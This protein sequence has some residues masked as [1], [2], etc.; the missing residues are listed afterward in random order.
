MILPCK[1]QEVLALVL[2]DGK[3]LDALGGSIKCDLQVGICF[4]VLL[5]GGFPGEQLDMLL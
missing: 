2:S 5:I 4:D 1:G 3:I